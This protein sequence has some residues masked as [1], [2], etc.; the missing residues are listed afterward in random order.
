MGHIYQTQTERF[1]VVSGLCQNVRA[2]RQQHGLLDKLLKHYKKHTLVS[3]SIM[4]C[5]SK[6]W[7]LRK[8]ISWSSWAWS[9]SLRDF[10]FFSGG[11]EFILSFCRSTK[12]TEK[13]PLRSHYSSVSQRAYIQNE[14]TDTLCRPSQGFL[15]SGS[16]AS[17]P[18]SG[19]SG[20]N[21]HSSYSA[22]CSC[23]AGAYTA[24][25]TLEHVSA[26]EG[27]KIINLI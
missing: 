4:L 9:R 19:S 20:S 15:S 21:R 22:A 18:A 11:W 8:A 1:S 12:N 25:L 5:C 27:K 6:T 3:S 16:S 24:S 2:S 7:S 26:S 23:P 10:S 14:A 13:C 17:P